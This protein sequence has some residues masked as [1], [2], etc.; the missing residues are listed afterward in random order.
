MR[1]SIII[2]ETRKNK[3]LSSLLF[4][5]IKSLDQTTELL[6]F[7]TEYA[8]HAQE[9][10]EKQSLLGV[11]LIIAFGGDGTLNEVINGIMKNPQ[12]ISVFHHF[13]LGTANDFSKSVG[14]NKNVEQFL[15]SLIEMNTT[16]I[17]LGKVT[18]HNNGN[19]I[20]KYFLNIADAGLGGFVAHKLNNSKK[21]LGGKIT[22]FKIIFQGILTFRKPNVNINMDQNRYSGKLL[23][24]AICNGKSFG[25]GLIISPEA[26]VQSGVFN[27][28]LIGNVSIFDYL[29]NLKKIKHGLKLSHENIHYHMAKEISIDSN[30][31][32]EIEIDGEYVGSGKTIFQIL[33]NALQIISPIK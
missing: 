25:N 11:D 1:L 29:R 10:A 32:C 22:Y 3:K 15:K 14:V 23:T 4:S 21:I 33:P 9:L 17:D 12:N 24:L 28:T 8:G 6:V 7:K 31:L 5:K 20:M 13:P 26:D 27:I 19:I 30:E 18:C 2:K 16:K